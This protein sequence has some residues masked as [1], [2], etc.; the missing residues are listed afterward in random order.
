MSFSSEIKE[1]LASADIRRTC[2]A[3]AECSA[4]SQ[5]LA[6]FSIKG[7][8]EM[9][10]R[11]ACPSPTI[12]KRLLKLFRVFSLKNIGIA[13]QEDRRF[14]GRRTTVLTLSGAEARK[15]MLKLHMLR[16][17][18]G[19]LRYKQIPQ[20]VVRRIC[21][22]RAFIRGMFLGCGTVSAPEKGYHAEFRFRD[23]K[24]AEFFNRVLAL[25]NLNFAISKRKT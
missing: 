1:E 20:R 13:I 18:N 19:V 5:C 24:K 11:Y 3:T 15:M 22:Q 12:A 6:S 21:C 4:L 17:E 8:G 10:L 25:Q 7:R 23:P 9:L 2:C 14:G 16:R